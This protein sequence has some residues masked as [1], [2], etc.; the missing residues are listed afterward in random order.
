MLFL[1]LL[2]DGCTQGPDFHPP[3]IPPLDK[4]FY[5]ESNVTKQELASWWNIFQDPT[6]TKLIHK[7]YVQN[8]DLQ[9]ASLRILQARAVL[10]AS[11]GFRYPQLQQINV[12][13]AF[14]RTKG[15]SLKSYDMSFDMA[16]EV[17]LWGK[18]ARGVEASQANLYRYV[19]SY[20]ALLSSLVAE[21]ARD[22][23][24][25]QTTQ[26]RILYAKRN[27]TIQK[28]VT[29][30]TKVQFNSGNVSELD[31]QQSLTQLYTTKATLPALELKKI[32]LINALSVLLAMPPQKIEAILEKNFHKNQRS[33]IPKVVF[34]PHRVLDAHLL[35]QR[36]DIK[37]AEYSVHAAT[38]RI[39]AT[40]ALLYPHF[41]LF[42][43]IGL[44]AQNIAS[45]G[46]GS[47]SDNFNV[48]VGP[49]LQ[50]NILQYGRIK[51]Q[52]RIKDALLE[53]KLALY[54]KKVLQASAE[55][56]NALHGYE[57]NNEQLKALKHSLKATL[58]AFDISITQ[59]QEGLVGY[60]RL[61][62]TI[63]QLTRIQDSY[64]QLEGSLCLDVVQLYKAVGGGWQMSEG[65]KSLNETSLKRMKK[66]T[67]WGKY[68]DEN[69][70][71]LPK[72]WL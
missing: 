50:W 59:Y 53:E 7:V 17:D 27:I 41:S 2:F 13:S 54:N 62:S 9:M 29:K 18:Y 23:I 8:L 10:G 63:A 57:L 68:L 6:L 72:G 40:K 30:I 15:V 11:Q 42:G 4:A 70:T 36:P 3:K 5:H 22:Y 61:L 14:G 44:S 69:N 32:Q 49:N 67:D 55:V 19:A 21:V 52:I 66:R 20:R 58:R 51:N 64:A 48:A 65:K 71:K 38:A 31:M 24:L 25:Y 26:E 47:V 12:N 33:F 16:W 60:Q 56:L 39:G 34:N 1:L 45:S 28:R 46:F 43:T 35:T 37:A